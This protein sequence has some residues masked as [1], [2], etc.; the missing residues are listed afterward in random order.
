MTFYSL[1]RALD[2]AKEVAW[3]RRARC[4]SDGLKARRPRVA[5]D[6]EKSVSFHGRAC[7]RRCA[8][9]TRMAGSMRSRRPGAALT[10]WL[11]HAKRR[12]NQAGPSSSGTAQPGP[13]AAEWRTTAL[14]SVK[15]C[16]PPR[17]VAV[18]R[19][20]GGRLQQGVR[21]QAAG[22]SKGC[23]HTTTHTAMRTPCIC[24]AYAGY[25]TYP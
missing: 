17:R 24:H 16:A 2:A 20:A 7:R 6:A 15:A 19:E 5:A 3:A 9:A 21:R 10:W 22:G 23:T 18:R 1:F 4:S 12:R 25:M 13:S 8:A 14:P 11:Y